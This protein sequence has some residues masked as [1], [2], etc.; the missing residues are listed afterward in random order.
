[1][2]RDPVVALVGRCVGGRA[3]PLLALAISVLGMHPVVQLVVDGCLSQ[4]VRL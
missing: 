3:A 4:F 2:E 1:M